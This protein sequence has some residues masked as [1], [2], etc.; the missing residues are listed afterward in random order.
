MP[1]PQQVERFAATTLGSERG[2]PHTA[3]WNDLCDE[4]PVH[5]FFTENSLLWTCIYIDKGVLTPGTGDKLVSYSAW[6]SVPMNNMKTYW[7]FSSKH[8]ITVKIFDANKERGETDLSDAS[9]LQSW[10]YFTSSHNIEGRT[11]AEGVHW[12]ALPCALTESRTQSS[13]ALCTASPSIRQ[14]GEI[15]AGSDQV[16]PSLFLLTGSLLE[17]VLEVM[18]RKIELDLLKGLLMSLF[19]KDCKVWVFHQTPPQA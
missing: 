14:G 16:L 5:F 1:S 6:K 7:F 11:R 4:Q 15:L 19:M 10:S 9:I 17:S 13:P 3:H 2:V 8:I 12:A 18:E